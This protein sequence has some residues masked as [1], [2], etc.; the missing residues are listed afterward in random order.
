MSNDFKHEDFP[1][2]IRFN[3]FHEALPAYEYMR[4][5]YKSKY[6][7]EVYNTVDMGIYIFFFKRQELAIEI[8]LKFN[9]VTV[10][11]KL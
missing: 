5:M 11:G 4:E 1:Y 10:N 7:D 8:N 9:G 2:I 3:S 6:H